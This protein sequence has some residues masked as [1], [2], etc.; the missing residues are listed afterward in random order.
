MGICPSLERQCRLIWASREWGCPK[1]QGPPLWVALNN[2]RLLL[3]LSGGLG[4]QFGGFQ[5]ALDAADL[6][7]FGDGDTAH[8]YQTGGGCDI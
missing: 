6:A 3:W 5:F 2:L 7:L 1:Q 8:Q 4:G